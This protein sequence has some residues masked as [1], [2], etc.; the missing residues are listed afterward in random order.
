MSS[1]PCFAHEVDPAH[2]DPARGRSSPGRGYRPLLPSRAQAA[3]GRADCAARGRAKGSGRDA[4]DGA[5]GAA[6]RAVRAGLRAS[7]RLRLLAEQ[8]RARPSRPVRA[9]ACCRRR[10]RVAL[11]ETKAPPPVFRRG[12]PGDRM[13]RGHWKFPVQPDDANGCEKVGHGSGGTI[14]RRAACEPSTVCPLWRQG[15]RGVLTVETFRRVRWADFQAGREQACVR[16]R[17]LRRA[18]ASTG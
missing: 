2:F 14:T 13:T 8:V 11:G 18:T 5:R 17:H 1:P 9:A 6:R 15:A 16:T 10:H 12:R 7:R 3:A 4:R